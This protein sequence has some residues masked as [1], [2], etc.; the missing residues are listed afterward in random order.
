MKVGQKVYDRWWPWW[1]I[2]K[3][4]KVFKTRVRVEFPNKTL[5]YD[6]AHLQFLEIEK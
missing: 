3:V 5:T 2:G 6:K 4:T 1:G